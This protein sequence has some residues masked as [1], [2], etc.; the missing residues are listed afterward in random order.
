MGAV[1]PADVQIQKLGLGPKCRLC[2]NGLTHQFVDLGM[3]P[4]CESFVEEQKI[5][6]AETYFPLRVLVCDKCFLVQLRDYVAPDHI[7][8]EYAYFSSY[9]QSWVAHA[10]SYCEMITRRLSL[11][12][13]SLVVE[14]ASNDGY[15]L[16][17]FVP[18]NIPI[19]GIDPA[20]NVARVAQERG[21]PTRVGFFG[22]ELAKQ[23]AA[24]GVAADLIAANNVVAHVPDLN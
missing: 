6:S 18:L 14:L 7:F 2:G 22:R 1:H 3:S 17:H 13:D 8:S 11:D 10:K 15:L 16:Q 12:S 24:D 9:S 19:L 20:A 21:I 4:L 23:L 5:D